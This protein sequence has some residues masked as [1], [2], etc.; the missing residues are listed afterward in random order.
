MP[1][2]ADGISGKSEKNKRKKRKK[3]IKKKKKLARPANHINKHNS[4]EFLKTPAH[5][6]DPTFNGRN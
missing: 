5:N 6:E 3:I 1:S 2:I 4:D